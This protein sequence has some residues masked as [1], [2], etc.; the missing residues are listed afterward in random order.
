MPH[1]SEVLLGQIDHRRRRR[2]PV[3]LV[4][5][6]DVVNRDAVCH[7]GENW[8]VQCIARALG[9]ETLG[10][11]PTEMRSPAANVTVCEVSEQVV[12]VSRMVQTTLLLAPFWRT[13]TT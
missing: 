11:T 4:N 10:A 7:G 13:A 12:A 1:R 3:L 5:H 9:F 6:A 2:D 8:A